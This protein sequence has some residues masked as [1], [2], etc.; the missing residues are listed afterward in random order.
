MPKIA[1]QCPV[2]NGL[3]EMRRKHAFAPGE[4]GNRSGDLEDAIVSPGTQMELF[5]CV[6]QELLSLGI[7][8]A[9]RFEKSVGHLRVG[10]TFWLSR[11]ALLLDL[12]R[13]EHTLTNCL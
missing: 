7:Q 12:A 1:I 13:G 10:A 9:M 5:H 6:V 4:I 3:E 8:L 11:E 2:L